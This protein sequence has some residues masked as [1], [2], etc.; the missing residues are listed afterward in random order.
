MDKP[1]KYQ[2]SFEKLDMWQ[3]S[4]RLTKEIYE[5]TS[6][7]PDEERFG[8]TNQLR[9]ATVSVSSNIAE[10][11]ARKSFKDQAY[12]MERSY[13]SCTEIIC[14]LMLPKDLIF[15]TDDQYGEIRDLVEELTNKLNA[16]V[17]HLRSKSTQQLTK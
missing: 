7:F 12:M 10:G 3:L 8:L 14:Q 15:I 5:L 11:S 6:V 13:G 1:E 17:R 16:Y 2:F 4:R 9:R